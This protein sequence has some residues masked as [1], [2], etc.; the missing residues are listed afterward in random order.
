MH[1]VRIDKLRSYLERNL[2]VIIEWPPNHL[3]MQF[4]MLSRGGVVFQFFFWL[5]YDTLF[6]TTQPCLKN[7][8][9]HHLFKEKVGSKTNTKS[10]WH[11]EPW[12]S[13]RENKSKYKQWQKH[14]KANKVGVHFENYRSFLG[15][16]ILKLLT[17]GQLAHKVLAEASSNVWIVSRGSASSSFPTCVFLSSSSISPSSLLTIL[18]QGFPTLYLLLLASWPDNGFELMLGVS[19]NDTHPILMSSNNLFLKA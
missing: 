12:L 19:S 7:A 5:F 11:H 4:I 13:I 15:H 10:S 8:E 3:S 9:S 17:L 16:P 14:A 6:V 18:D 2:Q 1:I